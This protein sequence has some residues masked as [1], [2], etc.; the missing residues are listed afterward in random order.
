MEGVDLGQVQVAL[1][2]FVAPEIVFGLGA[3][4]LAGQYARNLGARRVL[5]VTDPGVVAAGWA[6]QVAESLAQAMLPTVLYS[7]VSP[8]PRDAEVAAGVELYR[9]Q[10]CDAL[11]A[12]GG[13]S[14]ID[15]AKGIG[16]LAANGGKILDFVGVDEVPLPMPPLLCVPTTGGTSADI[17]QFAIIVD[18]AA[19]AKEA[20]ISKAVVP[21][22]SLV[23]PATLT[24]MDP[25][26]AACTAFDALV[27]AIEAFVS[28]ASSPL[29]DVHALSAIRLVYRNLV[30]SL[31]AP[32]DLELRGQLMLGSLEAGLAFSNAS[33]GAVHAMA[34]SLGGFC[35]L[36]HGEC[37]ALLLDHVLAF[38]F[39]AAEERYEQ[40]S[41]AMG[42]DTRGLTRKEKLAAILSAVVRLRAD[43]GITATLEARGVHRSDV[44]ELAAKAYKDP[45]SVT[46]PRPV[47]RRDLE[48]IYEEAL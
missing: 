17:S 10:G 9:S 34:H 31:S 13:G 45:C 28:N 20:I 35:D 26:L 32:Q 14:P 36:P 37:N 3:R 8:N 46:N 38:N 41:Q 4:S 2:K 16:I 5:L 40:I 7:G 42:L 22:V 27:H 1:R 15:C 12:V 43:A 48:V 25:F 44:R 24:T 23:D 6:G 29:T 47:R 30:R 18:R 11:V 19:R 33:L 21:D 39:S